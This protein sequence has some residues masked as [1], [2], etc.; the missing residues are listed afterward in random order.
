MAKQDMLEGAL[1]MVFVVA[2]D[3]L[4]AVNIGWAFLT[5]WNSILL[6]IV[7]ILSLATVVSFLAFV[8]LED[9]LRSRGWVANG[10][11]P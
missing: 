8:F 7:P 1:F 11:R 2:T 4:V 9:Y 6:A 3:V 5:P 10:F